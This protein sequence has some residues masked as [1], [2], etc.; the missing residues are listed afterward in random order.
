MGMLLI[1]ELNI[2]GCGDFADVLV[3]TNQPV[4]PEQMKKLTEDI[5]DHFD[6]ILHDC[7][8]GIEQGIQNVMQ[9]LM[10]RLLWMLHQ[11]SVHI[12]AMQR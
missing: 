2:N 12:T 5:R 4:T 1:R 8:A 9:L 7:P 10:E 6:F 11:S 3:Q